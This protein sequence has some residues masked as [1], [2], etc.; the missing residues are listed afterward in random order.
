MYA[1][2]LV[3]FVSLSLQ[4]TV[5]QSLPPLLAQPREEVVEALGEPSAVFSPRASQVYPPDDRRKI[6]SASPTL[7]DIYNENIDGIEFEIRVTYNAEDLVTQIMFAPE[8]TLHL[9]RTLAML[10]WVHTLCPSD[11]RLLEKTSAD[12][13][14]A[15]I[16]PAKVTPTQSQIAA[17]MADNLK[18]TEQLHPQPCLQASFQEKVSAGFH[19]PLPDFDSLKIGKIIIGVCDPAFEKQSS[20]TP[21]KESALPPLP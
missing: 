19:G 17:S 16:Y 11:C 20:S 3:M 10:P 7:Q 5:G 21:S 14:F 4:A 12:S 9:T 18:G 13:Y 6:R 2:L 8:S 15:Y 1:V